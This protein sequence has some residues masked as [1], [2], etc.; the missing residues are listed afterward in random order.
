MGEEADVGGG[1]GV[2]TLEHGGAGTHVRW[3]VS[4]NSSRTCVETYTHNTHTTQHILKHTYTSSSSSSSSFPSLAPGVPFQR[5]PRCP[6]RFPGDG[7]PPPGPLPASRRK[8]RR[9]RSNDPVLYKQMVTSREEREKGGGGYNRKR[10]TR[11]RERER[12]VGDP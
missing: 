4:C 9:P 5:P 1:R 10:E 7:R 8:D 2:N 6:H 11:E 3:G 12:P